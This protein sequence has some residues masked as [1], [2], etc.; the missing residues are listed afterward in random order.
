MYLLDRKNLKLALFGI[1]TGIFGG[2]V[3][4]AYRLLLQYGEKIMFFITDFIHGN[5]LFIAL[6]FVILIIF[7]LIVAFLLKKEPYISGSGIPQVEA[8]HEGH[9]N[10][11]WYSVLLCKIA[12]GVL[13]ILGGLSL[14]REGPSIQLGAMSGKGIAKIF[15]KDKTDSSYLLACG[16]SAGLAAAFNAPLAG[17]MFSLEEVYKGFSPLLVASLLVSSFTADFISKIFFGQAPVFDF[18]MKSAVPLQF[19]PYIILMGIALGLFGAVYNYTIPFSQKL[20]KKIALPF[21]MIIPFVIAG[22][23]GLCLPQVLGGGHRM[24]EILSEGASVKILIFLLIAKFIFSAVSFGSGAPGGIFFPLLVLGAYIGGIFGGFNFCGDYTYNM[25]AIGMAGLFTAIVR[26]PV[27]GI[28]LI[29]EMTGTANL[30]PFLTVSAVS[31]ITAELLKAQPIYDI[32]LKNIIT[33]E[34]SSCK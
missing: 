29:C 4:I 3:T 30:L 33:S 9:I 18:A 23:L 24:I 5:Y 21:R 19:Y 14:G 13:C 11:R 6:W 15:K 28:I 34:E 22:I 1:L 10:P 25:I 2:L 16:A 12:G 31:Y 20:F 26:A 32:L 27:T 8:E 17:V 7:G